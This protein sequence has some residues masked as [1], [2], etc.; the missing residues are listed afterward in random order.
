MF[1]PEQ[2]LPSPFTSSLPPHVGKGTRPHASLNPLQFQIR[3]THSGHFLLIMVCFLQ[4]QI[5][6]VHTCH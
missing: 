5:Q 2:A 3:C 6:S 1:I 4:N